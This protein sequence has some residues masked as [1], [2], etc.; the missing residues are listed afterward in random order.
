MGDLL[1]E[2]SKWLYTTPLNGFA[3]GISESWLSALVVS[4]F[5]TIPL[6]QTVHILAI[7]GTLIAVL[8]LNLR[9]FG[10]AGHAT[11]QETAQ[12]YTK[13]LWWALVLVAITGVGMLFGDTARN[14]LNSVFWI[15]MALLTLGVTMALGYSRS[16]ARQSVGGGEVAGAA[17]RTAGIV[18]I[19]LW[20]TIILAGR[21]IAYAPS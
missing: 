15:K 11:L 19:A 5:W 6:M 21:W 8:M 1:F 9:V 20:C 4:W 12:R 16:L 14:L 7:A 13:V 18:L 3:Q 17:T 10:L 2:I